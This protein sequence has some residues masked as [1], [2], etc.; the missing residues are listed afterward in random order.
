MQANIVQSEFCEDAWGKTY[1]AERK[2]I[3]IEIDLDYWLDVATHS[4][5]K[6]PI[7]SFRSRKTVAELL[8]IIRSQEGVIIRVEKL[9]RSTISFAACFSKSTFSVQILRSRVA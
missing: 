9:V 7:F 1:D 4:L 6:I 2:E 5:P 8:E 3:Q